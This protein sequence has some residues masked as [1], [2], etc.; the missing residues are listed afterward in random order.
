MFQFSTKRL[1]KVVYIFIIESVSSGVKN[2]KKGVL[3]KC[4]MRRVGRTHMLNKISVKFY[5]IK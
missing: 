3:L 4:L 5:L 1:L 2:R